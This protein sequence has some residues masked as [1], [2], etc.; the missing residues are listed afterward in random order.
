[1]RDTHKM[2]ARDV[3]HIVGLRHGYDD[4]VAV[5]LRKRARWEERR[6]LLGE[7]ATVAIWGGAAWLWMALT[8]P[9]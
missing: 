6:E 9:I 7:I 1:M 2:S 4:P 3:A 5:Q 8:W